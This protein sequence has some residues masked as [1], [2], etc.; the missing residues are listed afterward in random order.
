MK[1]E[2]IDHICFAVKDLERT[3][4]IYRDNFGLLPE[5]EYVAESEYIKVARYYIGG[6]AVEFMESTSPEGEVAKFVTKRGEGVYLIS[7]KVDDL[8]A[9][10]DE[11]KQKG[12]RLID[13]EPR[14]LFGNRY[15][16]VQ[17]PDQLCGVLTELLDGDFDRSLVPPLKK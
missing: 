3:K 2:R 10:L 8:P 7:Y 6:V 13:K 9:A 16:F 1:I 15:A 17:R 14:E 11:L 12:Q 4:R 5:V